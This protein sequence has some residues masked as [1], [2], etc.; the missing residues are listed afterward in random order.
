MAFTIQQWHIIWFTAHTL[1]IV[2]DMEQVEKKAYYQTFVFG[3][4]TIALLTLIIMIV[5]GLAR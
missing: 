5:I 1:I 4:A 3:L 2:I